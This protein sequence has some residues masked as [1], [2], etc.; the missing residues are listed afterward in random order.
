MEIGYTEVSYKDVLIVPARSSLSKVNL[1]PK[2]NF[3]FSLVGK[4]LRWALT[5]GRVMVVLTEFVV[6]L[7]FGSRF[8]FDKELNDLREVI[9]QKEMIVSS[10]EETE[11]EMRRVLGRQKPVKDYLEDNL[12]MTEK[13]DG[14]RYFLPEG[15]TLTEMK[16]EKEKISLVGVAGSEETFSRTIRAMAQMKGAYQTEVKELEFDQKRGGINFK[17]VNYLREED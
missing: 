6:I 7:A 8:W 2:D 15:V 10:Y 16:I 1:L 11:A 14:L 12:K 17:I 3:E 13:V 9:D 5:A 4:F